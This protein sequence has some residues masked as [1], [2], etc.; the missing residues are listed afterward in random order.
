MT[1]RL[2]TLATLSAGVALVV[3][4]CQPGLGGIQVV[5]QPTFGSP[6]PVSLTIYGA[7]SLKAALV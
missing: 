6:V 5:G 4:G 2:A 3:A 7:A 1:R